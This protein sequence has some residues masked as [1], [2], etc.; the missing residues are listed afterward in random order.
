M[1]RTKQL[2]C[3]SL[4]KGML[5]CHVGL[6]MLHIPL[7]KIRRRFNVRDHGYLLRLKTIFLHFGFRVIFRKWITVYI[8]P[9]RSFLLKQSARQVPSQV[10]KSVMRNL[11][12]TV[13]ITLQHILV[14]FSSIYIIQVRC[15]ES[16]PDLQV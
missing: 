8:M 16:Y 1:P 2:S 11:V 9:H 10:H 5:F 6:F 14:P 12:H 13:T 15:R 3:F 4:L 7:K